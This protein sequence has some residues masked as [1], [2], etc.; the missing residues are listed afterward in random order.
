VWVVAGLENALFSALMLLL[1]FLDAHESKHPGRMGA[2]G[3]AAFGLCITRPEGVLYAAPLLAIKL[4]QSLRRREPLR[5]AAGAALLFMAPLAMYHAAHYLTFGELVPNTYYAKPGSRTWAKGY[6]YLVETVR[7]SGLLYALPFVLIGLIGKP[8]LKLLL[9]WSCVAGSVFVLY[10][11]GDW[12]PHG[13]FVALFALPGLVLVAMGVSNLTN[14]VIWLG[15]R[16]LRSYFPREIVLFAMAGG[17]V[18]FWWEHHSPRL[19]KLAKHPWC[20]FCERVTD[21]STLQGLAKRAGLSSISLLT[22]DF[23]GPA[24]LS[25]E[26]LYPIDFLGLCDRSVALIRHDRSAGG[27]LMRND[28]RFYQYFMH[29]QPSPPSWLHVPPNFWKHFDLSPEYRWGYFHL[30]PRLLPQARR[31]AFFGLHRGELVDYFPPLPRAEFRQ[32]TPRL[33]LVG[34]SSFGDPATPDGGRSARVAAGHPIQALVSVVPR[35]LQYGTEQLKLRVDAG[36]QSV[37]S[38]PVPLARGLKGLAGQLKAGQPLSFELS[39]THPAAGP[40]RLWLGV[41]SPSEGKGE[42]GAASAEWAFS[43][44]GELEPGAVLPLLS[45]TLPRYPAA[46]PAPL[47]PELLRLRQPVTLAIEQRRRDGHSVVGDA[48]LSERLL[49]LA[50]N[51]EAQGETAQAYLSYVWA[52]QVDRRAWEVVSD[53]VFRLRQVAVDDRH[54]TELVLLEDYYA[55]GH[56]GALARLVAYYLSAARPL[57]ADHFLRWKP[58]GP[59]DALWAALAGALT[60]QLGANRALLPDESEELLNHVAEDPLGHA[61]D[62]ETA[63]L[64]AWEGNE[65]AYLAGARSDQHGLK[66]LRGHHGRGILSSLQGGEGARGSLL[67][68]EFP[69]R[70][71][72]L[73]LLVGGGSRQRRVGVELVV[74]G[75]AVKSAH[76]NDS[77]FMYPELWDVSA[78]EGKPARLRVFDRSPRSYVLIDRVLL[79]R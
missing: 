62:F 39:V 5:Q 16:F 43:D 73:S 20:H 14:A 55:T 51:F 19:H 72:M 24:W 53:A 78:Y 23:G 18:W 60:A 63:E 42:G 47:H 67:S 28:F 71:R 11:G 64:D 6:E 1:A 27:P 26:R 36:S 46:L 8:R 37:E 69:L 4:V 40:Y 49:D 75:T 30:S 31:D 25:D 48:S 77:D 7:D 66:G 15:R 61:L 50:K 65:R 74:E 57:E 56:A 52:T 38:Q 33:T 79:W 68:A 17:L 22:H 13:R 41:S 54:T 12:M 76:G 9:G 59:D 10:S 70:G 3:L 29:E 21:T 45:R 32:L 44:L 58:A 34:A 2:S 35:G